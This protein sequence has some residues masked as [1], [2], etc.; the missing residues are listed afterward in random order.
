MY[1]R[2]QR[3]F[4]FYFSRSRKCTSIS[5]MSLAKSCLIDSRQS[6]KS[7]NIAWTFANTLSILESSL[8][9]L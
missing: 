1:N 9:E 7:F 3:N 8:A 6:N 5:S 4:N 2:T